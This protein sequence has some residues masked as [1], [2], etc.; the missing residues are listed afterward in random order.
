MDDE[1]YS[2]LTK[3]SDKQDK[4]LEQLNQTLTSISGDTREIMTRL[5]H[6]EKRFDE[7]DEDM[8]ELREMSK[9]NEKRTSKIENTQTII[10]T[11]GEALEKD[12]E[13]VKEKLNR[14]VHEL[15]GKFDRTEEKQDKN[16]KWFIGVSI[17]AVIGFLGLILTILTFIF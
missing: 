5:D 1:R 8:K 17:P 11:R 7:Y 14:E 9:S 10:K 15:E 2:H 16:K 6:F 3:N 4:Q 12:V 13:Y